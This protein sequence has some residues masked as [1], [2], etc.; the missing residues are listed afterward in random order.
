MFNNNMGLPDLKTFPEPFFS[1]PHTFANVT[2]ET[3]I[4][5]KNLKTFIFF[6]QF[7]IICCATLHSLYDWKN[8]KE[9][10]SY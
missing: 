7:N 9:K 5:K 4:N 1:I 2:A 8:I 10:C 6:L 3:V